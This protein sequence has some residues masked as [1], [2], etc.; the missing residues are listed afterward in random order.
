MPAQ[1]DDPLCLEIGTEVSAKFKGAFCEAKIASCDKKIRVKVTVK[2][3]PGETRPITSFVTE[4]LTALPGARLF[5][6]EKTKVIISGKQYDCQITV[7][8]DISDYHVV[9][10]DGDT[11]DL[12]RSQM[13]LKGKRHYHSDRTLDAMPLTNPESFLTP[14]VRNAA[15]RA[16]Q[17]KRKEALASEP[18]TS[19]QN[20]ED[21]DDYNDDEDDVEEE[22]AM[23]VDNAAQPVDQPRGKRQA[24]ISARVDMQ[25]VDD[26]QSDE[27]DEE[28]TTAAPK[29]EKQQQQQS[30][31]PSEGE[32]E[33]EEDDKKEEDGDKDSDVSLQNGSTPSTSAAAAASDAN[34]ISKAERKKLEKLALK[35]E[36]KRRK[37]EKKAEQARQKEEDKERKKEERMRQQEQKR[38]LKLYKTAVEECMDRHEKSMR[39]ILYHHSRRHS[40]KSVLRKIEA[41]MGKAPFVVH[42]KY[43]IRNFKLHVKWRDLTAKINTTCSSRYRK[44]WWRM[45][46]NFVSGCSKTYRLLRNRLRAKWVRQFLRRQ[47]KERR[48]QF[49]VVHKDPMEG[50]RLLRH[51]EGGNDEKLTF[52]ERCQIDQEDVDSAT[53]RDH[54][55]RREWYPAVLLP[56]VYPDTEGESKCLC[57]DVRNMEDGKV[58]R[59]WEEDLMPFHWLPYFSAQQLR[60]MVAK[61]PEEKRFPLSLG[62]RFARDYTNDRINVASLSPMLGW[63]RR[64]RYHIH[65]P[66]KHPKFTTAPSPTKRNEPLNEV[67]LAVELPEDPSYDSDSSMKNAP[68]E[69]KDLFL[70]VLMQSHDTLG[71]TLDT[72]PSVQGHDIDLYYFYQL[73]MKIGAPKKIHGSNPWTEWAK[74][75]APNAVGAEE[76]VKGVFTRCLEA[77]LQINAKLNWT[78]DSMMTVTE[79]KTVTP[80]QY[81]ENRKKRAI[82]LGATPSQQQPSTSSSGPIS[83]ARG[84]RGGARGGAGRKRKNSLD[85]DIEKK[86]GRNSSSRATTSSPGPSDDPSQQPG[87]SNRNYDD[88]DRDESESVTASEDSSATTTI[89]RKSQTPSRRS[90][91]PR[92]EDGSSLSMPAKKGRPRKQQ[93]LLLLDPGVSSPAVQRVPE[94]GRSSAEYDPAFCRAN[95]ISDIKPNDSLRVFYNNA[96]FRGHAME[97][98]DDIT[99][100][101]L[102]AMRIIQQADD[103]ERATI[104]AEQFDVIDR[105][106]RK[107]LSAKAHYTGWNARY[108]EFMNYQNFMVRKDSQMEARRR[109]KRLAMFDLKPETLAIVEDNFCMEQE[110]LIRPNYL[111]L[112]REAFASVDVSPVRRRDNSPSPVRNGRIRRVELSED[113]ED[114]DDDDD[115]EDKY[116]ESLN[117]ENDDDD[118]EDSENSPELGEFPVSPDSFRGVSQE[119][120]DTD[121]RR[122][123][124]ERS[125]L[126]TK[127]SETA[128]SSSK[129]SPELGEPS[130]MSPKE[131]E[132]EGNEEGQEGKVEVDKSEDTSKP[133]GSEND[134][135]SGRESPDSATTSPEE[136]E[137]DAEQEVAGVGIVASQ[138]EPDAESVNE[139][140]SESSEPEYPPLDETKSNSSLNH[141]DEGLGQRISSAGSSDYPSGSHQKLTSPAP[142][143]PVPVPSFQGTNSIPSSG[144]LFLNQVPRSSDLKHEDDDNDGREESRKRASSFGAHPVNKRYR[145]ASGTTTDVNATLTPNPNL[146]EQQEKSGALT[147]DFRTEPITTGPIEP[148]V[149]TKSIGRRNTASPT[150]A[151]NTSGP[152]VPEQSAIV[153]SHTPKPLGRP[154]KVVTAP[155]QLTVTPSPKHKVVVEKEKEEEEPKPGPSRTTKSPEIV[156]AAAKVEKS[157]ARS[158]EKEKSSESRTPTPLDDE[159]PETDVTTT[160]REQNEQ[161]ITPKGGLSLRGKKGKRGGKFGGTGLVKPVKSGTSGSSTR[162][163][164]AR[165]QNP[166]DVDDADTIQASGIPQHLLTTTPSHSTS[167]DGFV[168]QLKRMALEMAA[169]GTNRNFDELGPSEFENLLRD[170]PEDTNLILEERTNELKEL[171]FQFKAEF[172]ALEKRF[173]KS[174]EA[175]KKKAEAEASESKNRQSTSISPSPSSPQP[176]TSEQ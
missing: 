107:G 19:R 13:V 45:S 11:K 98:K 84:G 101:L 16:Q 42:G 162:K 75:L 25:G 67:P 140:E 39:W 174:T 172:L 149:S 116:R 92:R 49:V 56:T 147:I 15:K 119:T 124:R 130:S 10:N 73:A 8:K 106:W 6:G 3:L 146:V 61:R 41:K 94:R 66:R 89:K 82:A 2:N 165:N 156:P 70:A 59:V 64:R 113:E 52:A 44:Q 29:K 87:P 50:R 104:K 137:T 22:D 160:P 122:K 88:E 170:T 21:E 136:T 36:K 83:S 18:S 152:L 80:G 26:T 125:E 86:K 38:R 166:E 35:E 85:T 55:H 31:V 164:Q 93:P 33:E 5:V 153:A 34:T 148:L 95:V 141:S 9:F 58:E 127:S 62:M 40:M 105:A 28:E 168:A 159:K 97:I 115:E 155:P 71:T 131:E 100:D 117:R 121:P 102:D 132:E 111:K 1:N 134:R 114:D 27:S 163:S 176:S 169:A 23:S 135:E 79:R 43:R 110:S 120:E 60:E 72:T 24:A 167:R 14:V 46:E 139:L 161:N 151:F 32:E 150:T 103:A 112:A 129:L 76:E 91:M 108:D 90:L 68:Q 126:S 17:Q 37:E 63:K 133:S 54:L 12:R 65:R 143:P 128:T 57:R 51:I 158:V 69:K 99:H 154:K 123:S 20:P 77:Y 144:P 175:A 96:W 48:V 109:F 4:D 173:R 53:F 47:E 74:K 157:K 145:R 7:L 142:P 78:M 81:S 171:F 138:E 118:D 30:A